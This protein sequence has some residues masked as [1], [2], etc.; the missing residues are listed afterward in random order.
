MASLPGVNFFD[1]S[2]S[3]KEPLI[4]YRESPA[5]T[6]PSHQRYR[7]PAEAEAQAERSTASVP[8]DGDTEDDRDGLSYV[9]LNR[10]DSLDRSSVGVA[11]MFQYML[12]L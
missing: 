1:V 10:D 2:G 3:A 6:S 4:P 9:A 5:E 8:K 12:L 11:G 7:A